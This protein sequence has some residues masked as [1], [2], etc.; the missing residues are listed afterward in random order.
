MTNFF[1]FRQ[2]MTARRE[3]PAAKPGAVSVEPSKAAEGPIV[4]TVSQLTSVIDGAIR[5]GLPST[6]HVEGELSNVTLHRGSGHLYFVLKDADCCVDGV[7][8]KSDLARMKFTP[9]DGQA[10]RVTG[11][12]QVYGARG[13][14]QLYARKI[15]PMGQGALELAFKQLHAKLA[16]EGLF[17]ASRKRELPAYPM[18]IALVTSRDG[19]ALQDVLKVLRR[20][21][22]LKLKLVHVPVQGDGAGAKVADAISSLCRQAVERRAAI[23]VII[24]A[25]GG[26]SIEDLWAFNEEVVA[27]AIAASSIPVVTGIGHEVDVSIADLVADHHAHT[28]TEAAQV[29]TANWRTA[30]ELVDDRS[31]RLRRAMRSRVTEAR[32]QLNLIERHETF[33]RPLDRVRQFRQRIDEHE[34]ALAA[35]LRDRLHRAVRSLDARRA[36]LAQVCSEYRVEMLR[37]RVETMDERLGRSTQAN[38]ERARASLNGIEARLHALSPESV[39]KRGYSITTLKKGGAVVRSA[40]DVRAGD[41]VVT[42]VA[43]GSFESTVEDR[44]QPKLFE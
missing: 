40:S 28:P 41:T 21:A 13:R 22:W 24:V 8:W 38:I 9:E 11:A 31:V 32:H 33:R 39:L 17:D 7:M 42:R 25:R 44:N 27:R 37:Q 5:A 4:W 34:R 10:V 19:A 6:V 23:D 15:E 14:Y 12:V 20:F 1:D 29:V 2:K 3:A 30:R 26:G 18:S 16:R 36:R 35:V 43:D